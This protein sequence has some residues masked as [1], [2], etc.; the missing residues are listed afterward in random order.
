MV[1]NRRVQS[2]LVWATTS[3]CAGDHRPFVVA[4]FFRRWRDA[5]KS[6]ISRPSR[7]LENVIMRT[8]GKLVG[9]PS[10]IV[11]IENA[12]MLFG[13]LVKDGFVDYEEWL[14]GIM[15]IGQ[16][17]TSG[18]GGPALWVEALPLMNL[19]SL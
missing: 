12:A 17:L 16:C 13:E 9:S 8:K 14:N 7:V 10:A 6:L 2:L 18:V 3:D 1:F 11:E 4:N 5:S 15:G 19:V